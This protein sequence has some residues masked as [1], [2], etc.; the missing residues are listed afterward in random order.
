MHNDQDGRKDKQNGYASLEE[1]GFNETTVQT[2]GI[3]QSRHSRDETPVI[4]ISM[5]RRSVGVSTAGII[6]HEG[7]P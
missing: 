4:P 7:R 5:V 3:K 2:K 1:S 6:T